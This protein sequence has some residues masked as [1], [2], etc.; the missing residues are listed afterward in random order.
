MNVLVTSLGR[1][2]RVPL[3]FHMSYDTDQRVGGKTQS[4]R[5]RGSR[6]YPGHFE[7][8]LGRE[9]RSKTPAALIQLNRRASASSPS[10]VLR[11]SSGRPPPGSRPHAGDGALGTSSSP[12]P[13]LLY[14]GCPSIPGQLV[15]PSRG[16]KGDGEAGAPHSGN[17]DG[18]LGKHGSG[19]CRTPT[20][21]RHLP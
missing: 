18:I 20:L 4:Q 12:A 6:V 7:C 21:Q 9:K 17:Q 11:P 14:P 19:A 8:V 13:S 3:L 2:L 1:A 15:T 10:P 16:G 5:F